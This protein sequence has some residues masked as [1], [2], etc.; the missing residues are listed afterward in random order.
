LTNRSGEPGGEPSEDF[1]DEDSEDGAF[2]LHVPIKRK[3]S[4]KR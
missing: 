2:V 4:R 1:G 3:G